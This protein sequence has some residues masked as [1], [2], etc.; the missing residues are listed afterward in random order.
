MPGA[1][2][3]TTPAL[4]PSGDDGTPADDGSDEDTGDDGAGDDD[5]GATE[6]SDGIDNDGDGKI[7]FGSDPGCSSADDDSEDNSVSIAGNELP[8]TGTDA[9]VL[10]IAGLLLLAS[11]LALRGPA[12]RRET[13]A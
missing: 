10:G 11:G 8:F 3:T 2:T 12:R 1:T 6:C 5:G 9:V 7:D 13:G 4:T